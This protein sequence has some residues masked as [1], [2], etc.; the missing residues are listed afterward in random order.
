M[1]MHMKKTLLSLLITF[2]MVF[3]YIHLDAM[4]QKISFPGERAAN[5]YH[6]SPLSECI[7][8]T[9]KT[10]CDCCDEDFE[11]EA[12]DR[13]GLDCGHDFHEECL[14]M[15]FERKQPCPQCNQPFVDCD[16]MDA[17]DKGN[18]DL[19]IARLAMLDVTSQYVDFALIKAAVDG[20][21]LFIR[22]LLRH[23]KLTT[24]GVQKALE[25]AASRGRYVAVVVLCGDR[26]VG[27]E[28]LGYSL[29]LAAEGGHTQVVDALL[30]DQRITF[31]F[32]DE[33]LCIAA[34]KGNVSVFKSICSDKRTSA[35]G[36]VDAYDIAI[37]CGTFEKLGLKIV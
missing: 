21:I 3:S 29:C 37:R 8:S 9:D 1:D 20:K 11:S 23:C 10:I 31:A 27:F 30:C 28:S 25:K 32:I 12:D 33:A 13:V 36:H 35:K 5:E 22:E 15:L 24:W 16:L 2:V 7:F 14:F 18:R 19:L 34:T 6:P 26:R 4:T 17:I